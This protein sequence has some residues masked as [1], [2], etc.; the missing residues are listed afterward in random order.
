MRLEL[1]LSPLLL[2]LSGC[3]IWGKLLHVLGPQSAQQG[4]GTYPSGSLCKDCRAKSQT[5]STWRGW[6]KPASG[7]EKKPQLLPTSLTL[8]GHSGLID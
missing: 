3:E 5:I 1:W 8:G 7:H 4:N 6:S 2:L